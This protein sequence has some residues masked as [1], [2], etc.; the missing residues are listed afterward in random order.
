VAVVLISHKLADVRACA[1]AVAVIRAGRV[2][3][4]TQVSQADDLRIVTWM[5]GQA[6]P[7]VRSPQGPPT[8]Q[9]ARLWIRGMCAGAA[10]YIVLECWRRSKS[11]R[12]S[13]R[14]APTSGGMPTDAADSSPGM[15]LY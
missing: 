1:D 8:N 13:F 2:V 14:S 4:R 10:R 9:P 15:A 12:L 3:A 5:V 11:D 6:P 7:T